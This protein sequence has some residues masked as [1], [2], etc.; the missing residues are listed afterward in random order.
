MVHGITV[1]PDGLVFA[2]D[3]DGRHIQLFKESARV[4][5]KIRGLPS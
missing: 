4:G 5:R 2:V 1:A 3:C